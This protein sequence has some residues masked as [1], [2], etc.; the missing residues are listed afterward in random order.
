MYA[1]RVLRRPAGRTS[2]FLHFERHEVT[3]SGSV[4]GRYRVFCIYR[5][6]RNKNVMLLMCVCV[7]IYIYTHIYIHMPT[8]TYIYKVGQKYVGV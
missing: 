7:Y 2:L 3:D 5:F 4:K 6:E 1:D 8:H